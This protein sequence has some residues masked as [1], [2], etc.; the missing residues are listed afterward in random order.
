MSA[1]GR[2]GSSFRAASGVAAILVLVPAIAR[3]E[4]ADEIVAKHLAALGGASKVAAV[5][6][7]RMTGKA[8]GPGGNEALLLREIKRPG[9][10]R[11]EFTSQGL[12]GVYACDGER[13]WQVSPFDGQMEPHAMQP[14]ATQMAIE[15]SEIGGPLVDWKAKGYRL[16]L[17]GKENVGDRQAWK[18][19]L[20]RKDGA[21]RRVYLDAQSNLIVRIEATRKLRGH[22]VQTEA[23]FGDYSA[24]DG[25]QFPHRVEA[26]VTGRPGRL[27][28]RVD[29]VEVNPPLDEARFKAPAG[30]K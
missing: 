23:T 24:T 6:S 12:T 17:A 1:G 11:L 13:G 19:T 20:T 18:L 28:I 10:I 30:I 14:D 2:L 8:R 16:E 5:Q 27:S 22:E 29:T 15:Q 25:V 3:P 4:T 21:V 9:R 26:G 7:L